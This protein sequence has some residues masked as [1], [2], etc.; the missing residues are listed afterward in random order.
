MKDLKF[1]LLT[2]DDIELRIGQMNKDGTKATLLLYKTS[3]TD[4]DILDKVVGA[5]NWQKRFYTLNGVGIGDNM[6][7]IVVC[8]VGIY[9]D[10]KH[11]WVWKDD[12]GTESNVEQDKGVCSDAFKRAAGGSCWGIGRELYSAPTIW[13]KVE[14]KYDKFKVASIS[15]T[16]DREIK[17][18]EIANEKGEIVYQYGIR[19]NYSQTTEK[20]TQN[21][22]E[23][24][25]KEDVD[26]ITSYIGQLSG[27]SYKAFFDW[28]EKNF[29]TREFRKL[30]AEQGKIV[31]TRLKR[32]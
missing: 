26:F 2:K 24:I 15:Y 19:K 22:N 3:R 28:L 14:S 7:S 11:E 5:G 18:L 27:D 31:S 17:T 32:K 1:P 8:S 25:T 30:N 29:G 10:D 4:A 9:D 20:T 13:V 12:S 21:S 16:E 23:P 6:R